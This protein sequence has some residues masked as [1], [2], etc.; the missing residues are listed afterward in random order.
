MTSIIVFGGV[1]S[2]VAGGD[3]NCTDHRSVSL[4]V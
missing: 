3:L 2:A 1:M 4:F